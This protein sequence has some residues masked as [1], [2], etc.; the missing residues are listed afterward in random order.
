V[1]DLSGRARQGARAT[2][3]GALGAVT[4]RYEDVARV[5][6]MPARRGAGDSC[7]EAVGTGPARTPRRYS[8]LRAAQPN[9]QGA[10]RAVGALERDRSIFQPVNP[11]LTARIFKILNCATKTVDTK[12]VDET[13]LYNICKGRPMFFSTV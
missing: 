11:T 12:V 3:R 13:S 6:R 10:W 9:R 4:A 5:P 1:K 8:A 7:L 2:D